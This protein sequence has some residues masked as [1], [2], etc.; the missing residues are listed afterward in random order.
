MRK[1]FVVVL[2]RSCSFV[3]FAML[4]A[5]APPACGQWGSIIRAD[6]Q[7]LSFPPSVDKFLGVRA[8]GG[9]GFAVAIDPANGAVTQFC[10]LLPG[11]P[12]W[13]CTSDRNAKENFMP[14]DSMDVLARVVAMPISTWN[15]KG[16]DPALRAIG[17]TAQDFYA[18][19]HLGNDDKSIATSNLAGVA[20]AAIQGLYQTMRRKDEQIAAQGQA[21]ARLTGEVAAM[22]AELDRAMRTLARNGALR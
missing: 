18:A 11:T 10:N 13:Q 4:V 15:F 2:D 17:P 12:S 5:L 21:I 9:V 16:A 8:T 1:R 6:S 7:D 20:L 14:V 3:V 19:F 22:R